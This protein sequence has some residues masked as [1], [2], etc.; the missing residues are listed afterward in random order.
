VTTQPITPTIPTF[1]PTFH[2]YQTHL[3]TAKIGVPGVYNLPQPSAPP[4]QK[5]SSGFS[6]SGMMKAVES[7]INSVAHEI[8][9]SLSKHYVDPKAS[10]ARFRSRFWLPHHEGL[11]WELPAKCVVIDNIYA[12]QIYL[13]HN[14]L[15]F[16]CEFDSHKSAVLIPLRDIVAIQ[17][18]MIGKSV[19]ESHP[20]IV[21]F[22]PHENKIQDLWVIEVYT[23]AGR[24]HQFY[25]VPDYE[26]VY[27]SIYT[28]WVQCNKQAQL[29]MPVQPAQ[30]VYQAP[31]PQVVYQQPPV[32]YQTTTTVI[33]K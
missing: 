12:G 5:K 24:V 32:V 9:K 11:I 8:D 23:N 27:N 2:T 26:V 15:S 20:N 28:H 1:A 19:K 3:Y 6:F 33:K 22:N 7:G 31:P 16:Y 14:Y 30:P 17:K 4:T 29:P 13:S 18:S 21:P 25:S 10:D